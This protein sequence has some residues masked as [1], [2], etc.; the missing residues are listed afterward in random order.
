MAI[1]HIESKKREPVAVDRL[2]MRQPHLV[3]CLE[4]SR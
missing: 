1:Q 2:R 4:R 3:E